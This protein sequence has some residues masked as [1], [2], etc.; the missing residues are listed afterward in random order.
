MF[1]NLN[2]CHSCLVPVHFEYVI[3]FQDLV[4]VFFIPLAKVN[5][6]SPSFK[7]S[8]FLSIKDKVD[9][10]IETQHMHKIIAKISEKVNISHCLLQNTCKEEIFKQKTRQYGYR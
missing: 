3:E 9:I 8:V 10:T 6:I 1:K 5:N 7:S 4:V 2:F